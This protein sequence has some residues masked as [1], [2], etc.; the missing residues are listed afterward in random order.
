MGL[1]IFGMLFQLIIF[2]SYLIRQKK[3][4]EKNIRDKME[5]QFNESGRAEALRSQLEN[6]EKQKIKFLNLNVSSSQNQRRVEKLYKEESNREIS[7]RVEAYYENDETGAQSYLQTTLD[8]LSTTGGLVLSLFLAWPMYLFLI[9]VSLPSLHYLI[10][11]LLMMFFVII[12]VTV[13]VFTLLYF[14]TF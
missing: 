5:K 10:Q 6:Q 2:I 4:G 3:S 13:I 14:F 7:E 11:R 12:G 9:V 8:W 1:F